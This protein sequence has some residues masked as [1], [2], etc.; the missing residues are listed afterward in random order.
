MY[1]KIRINQTFYVEFTKDYTNFAFKLA[2]GRG[3]IFLN[4]NEYIQYRLKDQLDFISA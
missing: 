4:Q 1:E 2:N 3:Y